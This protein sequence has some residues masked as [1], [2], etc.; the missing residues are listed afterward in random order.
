MV[1]EPIA[2]MKVTYQIQIGDGRGIAFEAA[3]EV[4]YPREMLNELL[5]RIGGAAERR[6]ALYELP[7]VKAGLHANKELLKSQREERA[8]THALVMAK[9]QHIKERDPRG[10]DREMPAPDANAVAQFDG[11]I[12]DLQRQIKNAELRIP[13]LEAIIAGEDPPELFPEAMAEA[14]E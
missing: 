3:V 2:G 9:L 5:D 12:L 8:K 7:M 11:R 6:Q 1:E 4:G 10:R 13:Y 14:A